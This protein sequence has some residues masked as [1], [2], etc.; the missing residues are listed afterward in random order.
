MQ[1]VTQGGGN[2]ESAN[3]AALYGIKIRCCEENGLACDSEDDDGNCYGEVGKDGYSYYDAVHICT[4]AGKRLCSRAEYEAVCCGTGCLYDAFPIWVELFDTSPP[5]P[6]DG[7]KGGHSCLHFKNVAFATIADVLAT[8][9][10]FRRVYGGNTN[11]IMFDAGFSTGNVPLANIAIT[12][13]AYFEISGCV[14]QTDF[15]FKFP[16]RGGT[17]PI[18]FTVGAGE[19]YSQT[20]SSIDHNAIS[21]ARWEIYPYEPDPTTGGCTLT[22]TNARMCEAGND[23]IEQLGLE[24]D[25]PCPLTGP[26][27]SQQLDGDFCGGT[28]VDDV[29]RFFTLAE[30]LVGLKQFTKCDGITYT[31]TTSGNLKY[32]LH[33]GSLL[34]TSSD[35][36]SYR[37]DCSSPPPTPPPPSSSPAPPPDE[38]LV[39]PPPSPPICEGTCILNFRLRS[40]A[41]VACGDDLGTACVVAGA[42]AKWYDSVI[43][44]P[45]RNFDTCE[46]AGYET[47]EEYECEGAATPGHPLE[48]F[49]QNGGVLMEDPTRYELLVAPEA[50]AYPYGQP[51]GCLQTRT[52]NSDLS[53]IAM[54]PLDA[55]ITTKKCSTIDQKRRVGCVCKRSHPTYKSCTCSSP[56]FSPPAIPDPR[57]PPFPPPLTPPSPPLSP[58]ATPAPRPPPFPPPL[59]DPIHHLPRHTCEG[60]EL[61]PSGGEINSV[62][63]SAAVANQ[64]CVDAGCTGLAPLSAINSPDHAYGGSTQSTAED[65]LCSAAWYE[66]DVGF[67]GAS[68]G[69]FIKAWYA[70]VANVGGCGDVGY[71]RW[72]TSPSAAAACIGCPHLQQCPTPPSPSPPPPASPPSTPQPQAP[73]PMPISPI[74][75]TTT[76]NPCVDGN[77]ALEEANLL[78]E[79]ECRQYYDAFY[80]VIETNQASPSVIT[81]TTWGR[82]FHRM[83]DSNSPPYG[84]CVHMKLVTGVYDAGDIL[85]TN[86]QAIMPAYCLDPQ[87]AV[88]Y[89]TMEPAGPPP[90]PASPPITPL[91]RS[92]PPIPPSPPHPPSPPMAPPSAPSPFPPPFPPPSSPSSGWYVGNLGESCTDACARSELVCDT[93]EFTS[94][95]PEIDTPFEITNVVALGS[96]NPDGYACTATDSSTLSPTPYINIASGNEC[97]HVLENLVGNLNCVSSPAAIV[98][99]ICYCSTTS[100]A[101]PPPVP[102]PPLP[103]DPIRD[104]RGLILSMETTSECL[105]HFGPSTSWAYNYDLRIGTIDQLHWLNAY[106][107]RHPRAARAVGGRQG[108]WGAVDSL[109]SSAPMRFLSANRWNLCR[110]FMVRFSPKTCLFHCTR[111]HRASLQTGFYVDTQDEIGGTVSR[112]YLTVLSQASIPAGSKWVGAPVCDEH[113]ELSA[114]LAETIAL[115]EVRPVY[116]NLANEPCALI[117][118]GHKNIAR[119]FGFF[120]SLF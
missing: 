96:H 70:H 117:L 65:S 52:Y 23:D 12:F 101:A 7:S 55:T 66:N 74:D 87:R 3:S 35:F 44:D 111:A 84:A 57:P 20:H 60:P 90:P 116:L 37:L 77:A 73:P 6:A 118:V 9:G 36:H 19:S 49:T 8:P 114:Q 95:A 104:Q 41:E 10:G 24:N 92:P 28:L 69:T 109:R 50:L 67:N 40:D 22:I 18:F 88:C 32:I 61:D 94:R 72:W 34:A 54:L 14:A 46:D 48:L 17:M 76:L 13:S 80:D 93:A 15:S 75:Y 112:C 63:N 27:A 113:Y 64:A 110:P 81:E 82:S 59:L 56:P 21:A 47:M 91:P 98:A 103:S 39:S 106:H 43:L 2:Y 100:P 78:T 5:P 97:F 108:R 30:A 38:D 83:Y 107:V 102:S 115:L 29:N 25:M 120:G 16:G 99:R 53:H 33:E 42:E 31:A 62:Y 58:P 68:A 4:R 86:Y 119:F 89:C 1:P 26:H 11:S 85:W 51:H 71:N 79:S 45:N 105:D